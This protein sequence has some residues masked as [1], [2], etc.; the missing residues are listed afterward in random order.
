M[1]PRIVGL[2]PSKGGVYN[3]ATP[4]G[5]VPPA[6]PTS[7]APASPPAAPRGKAYWVKVA[8]A[9]VAGLLLALLALIFL[10]GLTALLVL[11]VAAYVL[12][13]YVIKPK[14]VQTR[15]GG[16]WKKALTTILV[17]LILALAV[18]GVSSFLGRRDDPNAGVPQYSDK[19]REAMYEAR[20][21]LTAQGWHIE[22][23]NLTVRKDNVNI[24]KI[25]I[26]HNGQTATFAIFRRDG[27][28]GK[29][30]VK[31]RWTAACQAR[32][33]IEDFEPVAFGS[34]RFEQVV[35]GTSQCF[36]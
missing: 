31:D 4:A 34:T 21:S 6:A 33:G 1:S 22:A 15:L 35:D 30:D 2:F 14:W 27:A 19:Q 16:K 3:M 18:V 36:T 17:L 29:P 32:P 23:G 10:S 13:F 24:G 5:P 26:Y 8:V 12:V 7:P 20:N 9:S 28:D 11:V 25:T